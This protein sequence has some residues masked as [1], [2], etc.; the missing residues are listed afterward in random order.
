MRYFCNVFCCRLYSCRHKKYERNFYEGNMILLFM[1]LT[2]ANMMV[3]I[4]QASTVES[5]KRRELC[6]CI[7]ISIQIDSALVQP[8]ELGKNDVKTWDSS[9]I[10][11]ENGFTYIAHLQRFV[12]I[13]IIL[14]CMAIHKKTTVTLGSLFPEKCER[15]KKKQRRK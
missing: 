15:K 14:W 8:N 3:T 5:Q 1:L 13:I 4:F 7:W 12:R 2:E 11:I 9:H 10:V 6:K